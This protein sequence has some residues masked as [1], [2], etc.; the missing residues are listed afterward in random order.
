MQFL[1]KCQFTELEEIILKFV[2]NHKRCWRVKWILE[3][4]NKDGVITCPDFNLYYKAT[5]LKP[6]WH[7]HKNNRKLDQWY[8]IK[9][10]EIN[11]HTYMKN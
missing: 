8:R 11:P 9:S 2:W 6:A 10:P 4:N 7:W 1:S 5:V 3:K